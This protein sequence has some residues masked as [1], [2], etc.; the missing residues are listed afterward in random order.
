MAEDLRQSGSTSASTTT[1]TSG[2]ATT[3]NAEVVCGCPQPGPETIQVEQVLAANMAQRVVEFTMTVPAGKP[4]IDQ[5]LD[6]YV[7]DVELTDVTVIKDKVILRGELQVKVMYVADLP[8]QPV[9][10]FERRHVRFTRDVEVPGATP[11]MKAN[12]DVTVEFVDYDF[13]ACEDKRKVD[14]TIVLKMWVRVM[15]TM[16]MDVYALGPVTEV[17]DIEQTTASVVHAETPETVY[18]ASELSGIEEVPVPESIIVTA[19]LQPEAGVPTVVIGTA[20]VTGN[21]VN[22]R[23]G[24]GT[25]FPV[26]TQVNKGEMVTLRDQAFG[27][28]KVTLKDGTTGWI[29]GWLLSPTVVSPKG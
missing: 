13:D 6:V 25:N 3:E 22:V 16:E 14:I 27:W 21:R 29:A 19:P 11:D 1:T 12:A 8:N 2:T 17:N 15:T 24:P 10:A 26:I 28:Y 23:T 20:T 7:K 4:D 5:V 18:K 9:H